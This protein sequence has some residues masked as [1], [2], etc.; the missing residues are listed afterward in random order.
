MIYDYRCPNCGK[1]VERTCC[2][3]ARDEQVCYKCGSDLVRYVIPRG[4]KILIPARFHTDEEMMR[5][6]VDPDPDPNEKK[7]Y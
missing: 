7:V 5:E 1:D 6:F 3:A 2:V 4:L